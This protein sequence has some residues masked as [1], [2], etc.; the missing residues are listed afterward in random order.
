MSTDISTSAP[1]INGAEIKVYPSVI[2]NAGKAKRSA[3]R[4]L[5]NGQG[6]L[7][8]EI[9]TAIR[10]TVEA[11]GEEAAGKEVLPV[12]V[13]YKVKRRGARRRFPFAIC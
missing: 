1:A 10:T 12:V 7:V 6:P 11:M 5:Q 9:Q 8:D 4:K 13:I 3:V 2:V